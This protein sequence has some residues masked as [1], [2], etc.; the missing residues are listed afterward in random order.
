M[1]ERCAN[2]CQRFCV[3]PSLSYS[4]TVKTLSAW[5][6][7]VFRTAVKPIPGGCGQNFL[8]CTLRKTNIAPLELRTAMR[9]L[10]DCSAAGG[11][12]KKAGP[13]RALQIVN[14]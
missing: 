9:A 12:D 10:R 5:S 6:A 11:E 8:F 13:R 2:F 4:S 3:L 7:F 14:R 1:R